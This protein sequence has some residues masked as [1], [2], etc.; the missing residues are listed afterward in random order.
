MET[1]SAGDGVTFPTKGQ[2][3]RVHY[4]ASRTSDGITIDDSRA[5]NEPIQVR[6]GVGEVIEAWD[7]AVPLMSVGQRAIV[8]SVAQHAYGEQGAADGAIPPGATL[9]FE[10]EL[11]EIVEIQAEQKQDDRVVVT[12]DTEE[13]FQR[14]REEQARQKEEARKAAVVVR[15]AAIDEMAVEEL[16]ALL[17]KRESELYDVQQEVVSTKE[18]LAETQSLKEREFRRANNE[19]ME[20]MKVR[21]QLGELTIQLNMKDAQLKETQQQLTAKKDQMAPV[22]VLAEHTWEMEGPLG[23]KLSKRPRDR[24]E[25]CGLS[26]DSITGEGIPSILVGLRIVDVNGSDISASTYDEAL[27]V[28]KAAG[29]PLNLKFG[30]C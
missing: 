23:L 7:L 13:Q 27:A 21:E 22:T 1:L 24:Q 26:V 4:T 25:K 20:R 10:L 17:K 5:V 8:T 2:G 29:R 19:R 12:A 28:I 16:R 18:T 11:L 14:Q 6:I 15:H 30:K 9:R 3:V